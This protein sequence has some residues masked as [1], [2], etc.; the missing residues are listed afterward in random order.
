VMLAREALRYRGPKGVRIKSGADVLV[1]AARGPAVA[2]IA[3]HI[4]SAPWL[5]TSDMDLLIEESAGFDSWL[6][7]E[8]A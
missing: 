1:V 8:T 2:S 3:D 4:K 7:D 5:D 6:A